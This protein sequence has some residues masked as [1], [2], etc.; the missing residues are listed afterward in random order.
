MHKG[1]CEIGNA[2]FRHAFFAIDRFGHDFKRTTRRMD[3]F[4]GTDDPECVLKITA[5]LKYVIAKNENGFL[6]N[7]VIEAHVGNKATLAER[8]GFF[9]NAVRQSQRAG[10]NVKRDA[11]ERRLAE[12]GQ[13]NQG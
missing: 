9:V 5:A 11:P 7:I 2:E 8:I 6:E 4:T 10:C 3:I 1:H 13:I 12:L